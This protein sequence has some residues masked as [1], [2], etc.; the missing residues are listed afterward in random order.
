MADERLTDKSELSTVEDGDKVHIVDVSD[1]S[2]NAAGSSKW[3]TKAN[4]VGTPFGGAFTDLS[5]VDETTLTGNEQKVPIVTVDEGTDPATRK[6]KFERLP[7]YKDLFGG[8]AIIKGGIVYRGTG[9]GLLY[10]AWATSYIINGRY[11]GIPVSADVTQATADAT[12]D[13]IDVFA[14]EITTAEPPVASIVIIEGTP[15]ASPV[16]PSI[17]LSTQVEI[18]F[19]TVPAASTTDTDAVTEVIYDENTGETAEW[20]ATT[21][22]AGAN[23]ADTTDPKIGTKSITLPAYPTSAI[24]EFTKDALYTYVGAD[25]LS[26]YIR[27]TSGL[28][29]KSSIQFKLKNGTSY[30]N[31]NSKIVNLIDYGYVSSNSDWQLIQ[32]PLSTFSRTDR[33]ITQYEEFEVTFT[34]TPIIELDWI[35][36]QGSVINPSD[37]PVLE[38]VAGDGITVDSSDGQRPIVSFTGQTLKTKEVSITAAQIKTLTSSP[39]VLFPTVSGTII[40]INQ[41]ILVFNWGSVAFDNSDLYFEYGA[42]SGESSIFVNSILNDTASYTAL[43]S[44][45]NDVYLSGGSNVDLVLTADNDSTTTGDSTIDLYITYYETII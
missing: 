22:P 45:S 35:V 7:T 17:D 36:I 14:V 21:T 15:A 8:N 42:G 39:V 41:V 26:F 6:L 40:S 32:I 38:V 43:L 28:T 29:P 25:V 19:R 20:D 37:L 34:A 10:T 4:L 16:K 12:L 44:N 24:L 3:I 1:T 13:R 30:F 27:I 9:T 33:V 2:Q 5:D 31:F 11:I 23:I 18:S